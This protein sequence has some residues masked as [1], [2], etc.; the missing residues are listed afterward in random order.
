MLESGEERTANEC[1]GVSHRG[2]GCPPRQFLKADF[3]QRSGGGVRGG[4]PRGR[5]EARTPKIGRNCV[6]F[7]MMGYIVESLASFLVPKTLFGEVLDAPLKKD[8]S[9]DQRRKF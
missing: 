6:V 9:G 7:C 2:R 8:A 5:G 4:V 3:Q 1:R